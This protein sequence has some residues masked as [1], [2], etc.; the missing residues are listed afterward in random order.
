MPQ[1]DTTRDS[2]VRQ[3]IKAQLRER[4]GRDWPAG[5]RIPP[6][7][8]VAA[9]LGFG[10]TNTYRAV[11]DLVGE[12]LLVSRPGSGTFVRTHAAPA[13]VSTLAG[14][15]VTILRNAS[16]LFIFRAVD[17]LVSELEAR[18]ATVRCDQLP[19][20][21]PDLDRHERADAL[22]LVNPNPRPSLPPRPAQHVAILTTGASTP[23]AID[24]PG[25]CVMLDHE[26][27]GYL[28]G[29]HLRQCGARRVMFLG[30]YAKLEN[31]RIDR[32]S[33]LRLRGFEAGFGREVPDQCRIRGN[34]YQTN[35]GAKHV[36]DF[37]ARRPRFDAV[38]AAS[39][40]LAF[41]FVHGALAHGL[42]AGADYQIVGFDGQQRAL[43]LPGAP[44]TTVRAPMEDMALALVDSLHQR[45]QRPQA[46]ARRIVLA[47][48]L[49]LGATTRHSHL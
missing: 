10:R 3:Q 13:A 39:D 2:L 24:Q 6:L 22:V 45:F 30:V 11:Q 5:Q 15:R 41:G 35:I 14:R 32:T 46:P 9:E 44:L 8:A 29:R 38:F 18:G 33:E 49:S 4:I 47:T 23:L 26:Q 28:A 48:T 36:A 37:L 7:D 1:S 43:D 34:N 42:H 17:V 12:G 40:D 21:A 31:R 20:S 19:A 16:D 27:G 25:D